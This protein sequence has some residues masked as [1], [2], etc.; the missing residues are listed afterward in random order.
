MCKDFQVENN[1][2]KEE[3]NMNNTNNIQQDLPVS[4]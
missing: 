4:R 2:D 3:N 1:I